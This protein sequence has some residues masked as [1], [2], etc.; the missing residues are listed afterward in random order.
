MRIIKAWCGYK[1]GQEVEIQSGT[2][3]QW[4]RIQKYA[5]NAVPVDIIPPI[6]TA[7]IP[8]QV[9]ETAVLAT[10]R[11]AGR[12]KGSKNKPKAALAND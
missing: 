4:L 8:I 11:K 12:P 10:K 6:E 9:Q 5:V 7:V 2:L 3:R 1:A